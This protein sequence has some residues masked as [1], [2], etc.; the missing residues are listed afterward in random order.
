[1]D[2]LHRIHAALEPGSLVVDTQPISPRPP[3]DTG[4]TELGT[5]DMGEWRDTID[6][7]DRIVAGVVDDGLFALEGERDLTVT[8]AYDSGPE[9]AEIVGGWQGTRIPPDLER[10]LVE[11]T[12]PVRVHQQVRLRLFRTARR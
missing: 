5:L 6:T 2:A 1:M 12:E 7:I 10:R 4:G 8:D 3:V 11:T 9:F